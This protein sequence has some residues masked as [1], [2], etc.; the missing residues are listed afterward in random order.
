M[1]VPNRAF[2][3]QHVEDGRWQRRAAQWRHELPA[4]GALAASQ[5]EHG[6]VR[7]VTQV[8]NN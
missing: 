5:T 4:G 8:I 1:T 7:T 6:M 3:T 2:I